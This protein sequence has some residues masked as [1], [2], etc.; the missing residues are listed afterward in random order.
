MH[1]KNKEFI[2]YFPSTGK[3]FA[4]SRGKQS[5]ITHNGNNKHQ[6][7]DLSPFSFFPQLLLVSMMPY[8]MGIP[9]V[10]GGSVLSQLFPHSQPVHGQGCMRNEKASVV[11]IATQQH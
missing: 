8:G 4:I 7:S 5:S 1:S 11:C 9:L 3:Y 10:I 2:H 6:H